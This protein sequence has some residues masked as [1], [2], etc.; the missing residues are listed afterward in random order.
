MA[1]Q[2][3]PHRAPGRRPPPQAP[4]SDSPVVACP[5]SDPRPLRWQGSSTRATHPAA[6]PRRRASSTVAAHPGGGALRPDQ[7]ESPRPALPGTSRLRCWPADLISPRPRRLVP[8]RFG[9]EAV[10]PVPR[11]AVL[12]SDPTSPSPRRPAL[13][14]SPAPPGTSRRRCWRPAGDL[15]CHRSAR[16][17]AGERPLAGARPTD[18]RG[19]TGAWPATRRVEVRSTRQRFP[20]PKA[21]VATSGASARQPGRRSAPAGRAGGKVQR[22]CPPPQPLA[23]A[24]PGLAQR[25]PAQRPAPSGSRA[26]GTTRADPPGRARVDA[27]KQHRPRLAL[28]GLPVGRVRPSAVAA[29]PRGGPPRAGR[30]RQVKARG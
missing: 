20:R 16:P 10:R 6:D 25:T 3:D 15:S 21:R 23:P 1:R 19:G 2:F 28:L 11:T 5:P 17:A 12:L 24:C 26:A 14:G 13:P 29:S 30:D 27:G 7:P 4:V 9:G 8:G 18:P 22:T